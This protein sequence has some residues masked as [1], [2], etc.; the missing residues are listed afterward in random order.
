MLNQNNFLR[1]FNQP[2]TESGLLPRPFIGDGKSKEGPALVVLIPGETYSY[3]VNAA[4]MPTGDWKLLNGAGV[5]VSGVNHT[6]SEITF[7][8]GKHGYGSFSLSGNVKPGVYRIKSGNLYS[9]VVEVMATADAERYSRV[10]SFKSPN[11]L[12]DFYWP[13][14]P[15]D[16]RQA[17]RLKCNLTD[18]QPEHDK[19]VYREATTGR[20]RNFKSFPRW[21]YKINFL[22]TEPDN[23][24]ALAVMLECDEL[25]IAGKRVSFKSGLKLNTSLTTTYVNSECEVYDDD[26]TALNYC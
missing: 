26:F 9:N 10:F 1:W 14:L 20:T 13:Y 6:L 16:Y 21:F 18:Q 8:A 15:V 25:Y 23:C 19:E 4:T 11:K 3:Y 7:L 22:E 17:F 24:R 12:L 2:G 5:E